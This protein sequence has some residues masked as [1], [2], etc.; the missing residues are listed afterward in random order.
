MPV[1]GEDP[2]S[3]G[4]NRLPIEHSGSKPMNIGWNLTICGNLH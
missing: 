1:S 2:L 3:V 4:G